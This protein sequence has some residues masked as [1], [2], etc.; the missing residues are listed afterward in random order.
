MTAQMRAPFAFF[1]ERGVYGFSMINLFRSILFAGKP[2]LSVN[3]S[4]S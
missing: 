4:N 2:Q 1:L 3:E